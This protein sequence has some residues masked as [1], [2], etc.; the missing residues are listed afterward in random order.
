MTFPNSS[1]RTVMK[2]LNV[3]NDSRFGLKNFQS[4]LIV[5]WL[6]L[7]VGSTH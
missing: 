1:T 7:S 3:W 2:K 6:E 4:H 5:D